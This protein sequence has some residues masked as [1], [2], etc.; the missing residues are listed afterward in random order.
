METY[1]DSVNFA[2]FCDGGDGGDS[3]KIFVGFRVGN[4][5]IKNE[6]STSVEGRD[7]LVSPEL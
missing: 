3:G 1:M 6:H 5:R 2:H 4:V 7:Y